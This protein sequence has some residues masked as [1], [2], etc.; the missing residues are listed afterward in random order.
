MEYKTAKNKLSE[1]AKYIRYMVILITVLLVCNLVLGLLLWHQSGQEKTILV[2]GNLT[3]KSVVSKQ[4]VDANYLMQCALFFVDTR[5]NITPDMVL[6]SDQVILSH[7]APQ[8]YA[9]FKSGLE[10]EAISIK[11]QKISSTFYISDIKSSPNQL[12]VLINGKLRRWVG[13]RALADS[14]K[15]YF[16]HFKLIGNELFLTA[17]Q[18]VAHKK[19]VY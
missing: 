5:L 9:K 13:E 16:L 17:F 4:G 6:S 2:P 3:K 1:Y 10:N 15:T 14:N 18:E 8:Y 12:T 19:D 11:A 7:T